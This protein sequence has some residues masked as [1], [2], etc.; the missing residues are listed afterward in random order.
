MINW[1]ALAPQVEALAR[2]TALREAEAGRRPWS[3]ALAREHNRRWLVANGPEW[4]VP[5]PAL[6]EEGKCECGGVCL[7]G[8]ADE[9]GLYHRCTACGAVYRVAWSLYTREAYLDETH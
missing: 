5:S 7:I 1:A 4:L 2:F 6:V 8:A 3:G 9:T